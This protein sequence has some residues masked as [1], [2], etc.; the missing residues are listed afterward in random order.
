M[1]NLRIGEV[2]VKISSSMVNV[3]Q[4]TRNCEIRK[5]G[6]HQCYIWEFFYTGLFYHKVNFMYLEHILESRQF[7]TL[8]NGKGRCFSPWSC[9]LYCTWVPA[10]YRVSLAPGNTKSCFR[11]RKSRVEYTAFCKAKRYLRTKREDTLLCLCMKIHRQLKYRSEWC[12][13]VSVLLFQKLPSIAYAKGMNNVTTHKLEL[14]ASICHW[15]TEP[16]RWASLLRNP[17]RSWL[18]A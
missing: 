6:F 14:L 3:G 17:E 5:I 13:A 1:W 10:A 2:S 16:F 18:W 11:C 9:I 12:I 4:R 8:R 7:P 15:C